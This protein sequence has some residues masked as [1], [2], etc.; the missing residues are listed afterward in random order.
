[1]KTSIHLFGTKQL[2]EINKKAAEKI[3]K[4]TEKQELE[5]LERGT[6]EIMID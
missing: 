2:R 3:E 6:P 1:M 5:S 4:F